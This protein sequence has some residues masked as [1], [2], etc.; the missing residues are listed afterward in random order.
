MCAVNC[1]MN[2]VLLAQVTCQAVV[3]VDR[4]NNFAVIVR[5]W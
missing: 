4:P 3:A 5:V 1:M 2:D